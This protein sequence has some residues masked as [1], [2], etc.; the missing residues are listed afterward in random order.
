MMLIAIVQI[1]FIYFSGDIFRCIP[2]SIHD[3]IS[4]ILISSSV[5]IFDFLRKL[6]S[7]LIR[8]KRGEYISENAHSIEV[9]NNWRKENA[10]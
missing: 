4:T 8:L 10:R 6:V 3:L 7:K 9:S 5:V 1:C 2:L